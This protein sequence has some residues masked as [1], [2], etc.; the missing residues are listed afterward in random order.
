MGLSTGGSFSGKEYPT[1][2]KRTNGAAEEKSQ[3]RK[4][5]A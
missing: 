2:R 1:D 3:G 5:D 4:T